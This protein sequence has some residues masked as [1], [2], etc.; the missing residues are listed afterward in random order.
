M[1][2][3]F[4]LSVNTEQL[5]QYNVDEERK[6]R[7]NIII[8]IWMGPFGVWALYCHCFIFCCIFASW[9][10]SRWKYFFS[11]RFCI[12]ELSTFSAVMC[13]DR[14]KCSSSNGCVG[15]MFF[16]P[17]IPSSSCIAIHFRL[18]FMTHIAH[19]FLFFFFI[20]S[21]TLPHFYFRLP[22]CSR[23]WLN[24]MLEYSE[25]EFEFRF[26]LFSKRMD[27]GKI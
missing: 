15:D 26:F 11:F 20:F 17:L 12:V 10:L 2:V 8:L 1:Y 21:N 16:V 19:S 18:P 27:R 9:T 7:H 5:T 14:L 3:S 24:S 13:C 22:K 25:I 23:W 6:K 4:R